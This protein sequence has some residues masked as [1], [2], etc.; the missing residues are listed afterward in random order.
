[1][2]KVL[3]VEV[4]KTQLDLLIKCALRDSVWFEVTP[5][6]DNCYELAVKDEPTR[7]AEIVRWYT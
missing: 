4:I 3:R 2:S 7:T 5:L 1:M 6:P